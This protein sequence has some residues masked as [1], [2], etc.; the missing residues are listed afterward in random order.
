M[1]KY[2]QAYSQRANTSEERASRAIDQFGAYPNVQAILCGK[3]A[4]KTSA[5]IPA[6]SITIF[7]CDGRVKF[8]AGVPG[9]PEAMFGCVNDTSDIAGSIEEAICQDQFAWYKRRYKSTGGSQA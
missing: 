7:V 5:L 4:T 9:E 8:C 1:S 6:G 3:R 2:E